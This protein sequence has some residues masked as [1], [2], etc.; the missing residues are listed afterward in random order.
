MRPDLLG[1]V[2]AAV[3]SAPRHEMEESLGPLLSL[4]RRSSK[5]CRRLSQV[6][7]FVLAVTAHFA[8]HEAIVLTPTLRLLSE[9]LAWHPQPA[10]MVLDAGLPVP[11]RRLANERGMVLV[12]EIAGQLLGRVEDAVGAAAPGSEDE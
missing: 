9:L 5:L 2:V 11:V 3:H 10:Q 12:R 7:A 4:M 6:H 8:S 1:V